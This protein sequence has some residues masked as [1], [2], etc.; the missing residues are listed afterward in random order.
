MQISILDGRLKA[1]R[2]G[3]WGGEG[4]FLAIG[5]WNTGSYLF[6]RLKKEFY[7]P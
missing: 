2:L 5:Q 6:L 4:Q 3:G 1:G 7:V